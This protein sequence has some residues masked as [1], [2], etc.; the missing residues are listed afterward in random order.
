MKLP[1]GYIVS[2]EWPYCSYPFL[3]EP[4]SKCSYDCLYCFT[5]L[6]D[7]WHNKSIKRANRPFDYKRDMIDARPLERILDGETPKTRIEKLISLFVRDRF[8]IQIG[9]L[10]DP[11]GAYE[12]QYHQTNKL[13]SLFKSKGNSYPIRINLKGDSLDNSNFYRMIEGYS[14][15]FLLISVSAPNERLS[16]LIDIGAPSLERRLKFVRKISGL[17]PRVGLRLRPILP[18]IKIDEYLNLIESFHS[19]GA[20][21]VSV[22]WLRIPRLLTKGGRLRI[23]KLSAALGVDLER[24]YKQGINNGRDAVIRLPRLLVEEDY[25]RLREFTEKIGMRL[26]SCNKDFRCISTDTPNCCGAGLED[27]SWTRMQISYAL[28]LAK[29]N[30]SV[31]FSDIVNNNHPLQRI[32]NLENRKRTKYRGYSFADTLRFLWNSPEE[33]YYPSRFFQELIPGGMDEFGD[34]IFKYKNAGNGGFNV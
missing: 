30:G 15:L 17:G 10:T 27:G 12:L 21:V 9:G 7:Y 8:A 2:P 33:R 4:Y 18:S 11:A 31:C 26:A 5:K 16:S 14:Q 24:L 1:M 32:I 19:A 34:T 20:G 23:N 3:I 22:E 25:H 6:R 13:V 29:K 28:Y